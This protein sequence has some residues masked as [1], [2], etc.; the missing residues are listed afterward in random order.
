MLWPKDIYFGGD[1]GCQT[2][3][4]ARLLRRLV[5]VMHAL[6]ALPPLSSPLTRP[7]I[8]LQR[9]SSNR[10]ILNEPELVAALAEFGEVRCGG[11]VEQRGWVSGREVSGHRHPGP[12]PQAHN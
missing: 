10:R 1:R 7:V 8:T 5:H 9:K 12:A 6:P 3:E 2:R 4:D 11:L